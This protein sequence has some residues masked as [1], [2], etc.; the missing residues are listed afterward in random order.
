M[1]PYELKTLRRLD[2]RHASC[3]ASGTRSIR[4]CAVLD[5]RVAPLSIV[6]RSLATVSHCP[7]IACFDCPGRALAL[8]DRRSRQVS[9]RSTW[10]VLPLLYL[11]LRCMSCM[12][13]MRN[14]NPLTSVRVSVCLSTHAHA[15]ELHFWQPCYSLCK[16]A[17]GVT[18]IQDSSIR[19]LRPSSPTL[20]LGLSSGTTSVR[21]T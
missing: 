9:V 15:G 13:Y 6:A 20:G 11:D 14:T 4:H 12:Y 16:P 5:A 1:F 21:H 2:V 19:T 18:P 10:T 3:G 17:Q 8:P 7:H